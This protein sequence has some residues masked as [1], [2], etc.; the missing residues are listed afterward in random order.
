MSN[1][2]Q[3]R[4]DRYKYKKIIESDETKTNSVFIIIG[5]LIVFI[6]FYLITDYINPKSVVLDEEP[7]S[8][9]V[10][11]QYQEILAGSTFDIK[12]PQYYVVFYSSDKFY[13]NEIENVITNYRAKNK[14]PIYIVDLNNGLNKNYIF[15]ESNSFAQSASELKVKDLTLI[16]IE[17][18]KNTSYLEGIENI[19]TELGVEN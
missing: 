16:K 14:S 5:M 17:N 13:K 9:E 18:N 11:I 15:E 12:K 3:R 10:F 4:Q 6:L 7:E 2:K 1:R 8:K 19:K